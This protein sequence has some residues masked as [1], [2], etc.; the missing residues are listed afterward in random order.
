MI[1]R[2]SRSV[3]R[4]AIAG[5]VA[6]TALVLGAYFWPA[7]TSM[8]RIELYTVDW[9]F[10]LRGPRPPDSRIAIVAVDEA[11][12]QKMGRWPWDRRRMATLIKRLAALG[13][14]RLI[15]DIFFV[16]PQPDGEADRKLA[17]ATCETGMVYHAGL[18]YT[19]DADSPGKALD[20]AVVAHAWDGVNVQ[21]AT[22]LAAG[23]GLYEAPALD[24][25][26]PM[27]SR[28]A[29]GVGVMN[30]LDSG[31][32][33]FRHVLPAVRYRDHIF[34]SAILAAAKDM[35][36]VAEEDITIREGHCIG[37]GQQLAVPIDAHGRMLVNFAG[38]AN[39]YPRV[40]AWRVLA[41]DQADRIARELEEKTVLIAVTAPGFMDIRPSPFSSV[42]GGVETQA[43]ALDTVL[44]GR[45]LRQVSPVIV[46][47]VVLLI[48]ILFATVLLNLRTPFALALSGALLAGYVIVAVV[49]FVGPGLVINL[50]APAVC[51]GGCFAVV[52]AARL[53]G[54]ERRSHQAQQT[55]ARFI[56][57]TLASRLIDEDAISS[58]RGQR[59]VVTVLFADIRG[60]TSA[61]AKADPEDTVDLLNRYFGFMVD[62]IWRHEGTLDKY[63]GDEIMAFWNAPVYQDN[64]AHRAVRAALVMQ[65]EI[66][67]RQDEWSYLGMPGL[68][69]GIG[70]ST[71]EAIIG[72]I[73]SR[74]RMQYTAIGHHVNL[75][76][77]LQ[78]LTR[79]L[80]A[81]V[82]ISATTYDQIADEFEVEY[83]GACELRGMEESVQVYRVLGPA[84]DPNF[85]QPS[86]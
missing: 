59:R 67:K 11:S 80:D 44:N 37:L 64:H 21:S 27:F 8:D 47:I 66:D 65:R 74:E 12:I 20:P 43:N 14:E 55:L 49:L 32:G 62:T 34:P 86:Q 61:A 40:S 5:I 18:T 69:A 7:Q 35:L 23:A 19:P 6:W 9:R 70:I 84:G 31:D 48:G 45:F 17:Q 42:Y 77:R 2:P 72:Y 76:S 79:D 30:V 51:T 38:P 58:L 60:F 3:R 28:N 26:L 57:Q 83:E 50:L 10:R 46:G 25:P 82:L 63:I 22:G 75:A 73:G 53:V 41:G 85:L 81:R 24:M 56:P 52:L 15:F 68:Q 33:V 1:R 36:E 78:E 39:T 16:D 29:A 4:I 13:A 71:G 54:E